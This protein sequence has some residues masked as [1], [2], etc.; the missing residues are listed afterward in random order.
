MGV[1]RP[2]AVARTQGAWYRRWLLVA[3]GG[4]VFGI[5]DTAANAQ[6]FG[7]PGTIRGQGRSAYPQAR[8][9]ALAECGTHAVCGVPVPAR[10]TPVVGFF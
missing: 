1:C 10:H 3:V 5:P 2:V 6:L 8:V 4:T 7:R 9:A